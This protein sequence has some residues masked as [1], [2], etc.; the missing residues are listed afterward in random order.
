[1]AALGKDFGDWVNGST[2]G[3]RLK[4]SKRFVRLVFLFFAVLL[5]WAYLALLDEVSTGTGKVVPTSQEQVIQSL[6]GGVL[7]KLY[8]RQDDVVE[9]GKILAQLDPTVTEATVQESSA[10]YRAALASSARLTAEVNG[11]DLEFPDE[12]DALPSLQ[13]SETKLYEARKR[14]LKESL[15]WLAESKKLAQDELAISQSLTKMGAASNVEVIRLKRQLVELQLKETEIQ[16]DYIVKAREELAKA[17]AD[18]ESLSSVIRGRADSFA[19]LTLRSPVRG[20]VK[21]IEVSTI[22]GVVPPNGKLMI[23]VPLDEQL[24]IEARISPRDIAYI[25]PDQPATV[26]VTAYDYAIYGSLKG[27]VVSISPDTIQDEVK[28]E[29]FYYRVFIKTETDAL[30]NKAGERFPIVPGMVAT[31]DIHTGSKTVMDYLIKPF[32]RAREALRER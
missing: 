27:K 9:P 11:S 20:V 7:A 14:S 12:L 3:A 28:P 13:A 31:V 19:R 30:F 18:V 25:H 15:D 22:G 2:D 24:L 6:E 32:N 26:K 16:S 21:N 8:V 17:N 23:I 5:I 1:M 10:K 4:R 29:E